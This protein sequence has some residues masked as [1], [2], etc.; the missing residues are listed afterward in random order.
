MIGNLD[1]IRGYQNANTET[2]NVLVD[3]AH[4]G[5]IT[6]DG[7]GAIRCIQYYVLDAFSGV[8]GSIYNSAG[9]DALTEA[10]WKDEYEQIV[11]D[12]QEKAAKA[13]EDAAI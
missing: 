9:Y 2:H 11:K 6:D 10:Q 7:S 3:P 12:A 5:A 1:Y 13:V 4:I 8:N